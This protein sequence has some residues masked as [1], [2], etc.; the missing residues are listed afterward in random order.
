MVLGA[1]AFRPEG[2]LWWR[3][4]VS[5]PLPSW[6]LP[7]ERPLD[8]MDR[9]STSTS[10]HGI[11]VLYAPSPQYTLSFHYPHGQRRAGYANPTA[12]NGAYHRQVALV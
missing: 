4:S 8:P 2:G 11:A 12:R 7:A 10:R 5:G 3:R 1:R 9:V 6:A